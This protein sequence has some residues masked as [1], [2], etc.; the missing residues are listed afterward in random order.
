MLKFMIFLLYIVNSMTNVTKNEKILKTKAPIVDALKKAYENPTYQFHIP[1]HTK[2]GGT[3]PDFR[4]LIGKKAL[5]LDTTDEFD[6][7]GTLHPATGPIREAQE[8]AAA[9]FG[10]KKTFFLF[11]RVNGRKPCAC[12]GFNQ[13]RPE[14][15]NKQ[16]LSPLGFDRN[17]NFRRRTFM[18]YSKSL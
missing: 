15:F 12:N 6:G 7:L 13:K 11:K 9:A 3:L 4:K 17:D 8:L 10:A 2:G 1:G 14:N 16:K 18:A 5:S